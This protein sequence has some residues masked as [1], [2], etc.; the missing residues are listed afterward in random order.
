[1][2]DAKAGQNLRKALWELRKALPKDAA[3]LLRADRK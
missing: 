1:M 3:S 2:A